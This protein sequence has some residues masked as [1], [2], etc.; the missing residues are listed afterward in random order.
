M[1]KMKISKI[2]IKNFRWIKDCIDLIPW[3]LTTLVWK[4]DSWKSTMIYAIKAFFDWKISSDDICKFKNPDEKVEIEFSFALPYLVDD[5]LLDENWCLTIK[6]IFSFNDKGKVDSMTLIKINDLS[7]EKYQNLRNKKE[8]DLNKIV[9]ELWWEIKKSWA[10]NTNLMRIEQIRQLIVNKLE[11]RTILYHEDETILDSLKKQYDIKMP[12]FSLFWAEENLDVWSTD[13]QKQ[14]SSILSQSLVNNKEATDSLELQIESDLQKEFDVISSIMKR[15]VPELNRI[16][17]RPNCDRTKAVKF[18][19]NLQFDW[20]DHDIPISHKGTWFKRLLMVAYFEYLSTKT[21][22]EN[23]IFAI[24]EPEIYLHPSAQNNLLRSIMTIS[25]NNQFFISTHS[26]IFAGVSKGEYSVLV[27]KENWKS[28]YDQWWN[29]LQRIINELGI[30]PEY[31]LIETAK[32]IVFVEWK[33][34]V[35]FL[36]SFANTVLSKDL[37]SD[38]I[39]CCIG[40]WSAL[41]NSADLDLFKKIAQTQHRYAIVI[42]SDNWDPLKI[43]SKELLTGKCVSDWAKFF[44]LSKRE[45]EN[46]CHHEAIKRAYTIDLTD[47]N[48]RKNEI[49][50][51]TINIT[52]TDDI[53]KYLQTLWLQCFKKNSFNIKTFKNMTKEEREEMDSAN[54][55]KTIIE[56]IYS[57]LPLTP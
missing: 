20:E 16:V 14:F 57:L 45:V 35:E 31:N 53:E 3:N 33:D 25:N 30:L 32:Y 17:S 47:Q 12:V 34:D 10:W 43:K 7:D 19:I 5:L 15:N 39:I 6:K 41:K 42:D 28:L 50:W 51:L 48:P 56:I 54:E 27:T 13:F 36:K 4:N 40:W 11:N 18:W 29:V 52:D 8:V 1:N 2:S 49:L 37:E 24:E 22:A 26:P 46:Y 55:L 9:W 44:E 38:W 21:N 23:Q